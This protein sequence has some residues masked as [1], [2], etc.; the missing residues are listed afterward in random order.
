[1]IINTHGFINNLGEN[2]LF[3]LIQLTQPFWLVGMGR[4]PS[5]IVD[6]MEG[7]SSER[8]ISFLDEGYSCKK[9]F[10]FINLVPEENGENKSRINFAK[11]TK[12]DHTLVA[13]LSAGR[14]INQV[15]IFKNPPET[16]EIFDFIP[17][18]WVI[19]F[20]L[21]NFFALDDQKL[22]PFI[23]RKQIITILPFS[24]LAF[25]D[26]TVNSQ[27]FWL[28]NCVGV[29]Y[30]KDIDPKKGLLYLIT[31]I[32]EEIRGNIKGAVRS[33]EFGFSNAFYKD[34]RERRRM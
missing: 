23:S 8:R 16:I 29:G 3:D 17:A 11:K 21:I 14:L 1:M 24:L 25:Y 5:K 32:T 10:E 27:N 19:D 33:G 4:L 7:K 30:V 18:N 12:R 26:Q 2:L 28:S 34:N 22:T 13:Y 20:H 31:P 15:K 9:R 6:F